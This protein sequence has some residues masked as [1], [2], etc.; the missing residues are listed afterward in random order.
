MGGGA[1]SIDLLELLHPK[2]SSTA[3]GEVRTLDVAEP[4]LGAAEDRIPTFVAGAH[5]DTQRMPDL[6]PTPAVAAATQ[7]AGLI[8]DCPADQLCGMGFPR[9]Q[10]EE[11]LRICG[12]LDASLEWLLARSA[13]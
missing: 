10:V 4:A 3:T 1:S 13:N 8:G 11:A 9:E 2:G 5:A 7:P 12:R 6:M